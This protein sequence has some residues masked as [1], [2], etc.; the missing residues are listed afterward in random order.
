MTQQYHKENIIRRM[1]ARRARRSHDTGSQRV[2]D[3][4]LLVFIFLALALF[5][6]MVVAI[7]G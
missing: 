4:L 6:I 7:W 2:T 1:R 3:I 5:G